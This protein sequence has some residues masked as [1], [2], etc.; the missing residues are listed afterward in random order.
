MAQP[1]KRKKRCEV[2]FETSE[3]WVS[4][5]NLRVVRG[6]N[7]TEISQENSPQDYY[8][9]IALKLPVP[10]YYM[11]HSRKPQL[12]L[13]FFFS[14]FSSIIMCLIIFMYSLIKILFLF[15]SFAVK[16]WLPFLLSA[17]LSYSSSP[18][19][20]LRHHSIFNTSICYSELMQLLLFSHQVVSDFTTP[21]TAAL[22]ASQSLTISQSLPKFMSN[23][24]MVQSNHLILC[25]PLFLLPSIFPSIRVF[26]S[27]SALC[28][29]WPKY[30][31][32]SI[33]PSSEYSG[34]ISFRIDWFDPFAVQGSL[35][36][37]LQHNSLKASILRCSAFFMVQLSHLYVTS[38]K[39]P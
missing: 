8:K 5:W 2:S 4:I 28:I 31:S 25:H 15:G 39:K 23:E 37:L 19:L 14:A 13:S 18:L 38:G 29:R 1:K 12:S 17:S 33:S 24:L 32:F 20:F 3:T 6:F 9:F 7:R 11:S 30:W 21:W 16:V 22:Q 26:S 10:S 27:E 35:K 34:L 36:R